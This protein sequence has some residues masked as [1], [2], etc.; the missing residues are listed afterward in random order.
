MTI[1]LLIGSFALSACGLS[2]VYSPN[3]T[4]NDV[5]RELSSIN[6]GS[7]PEKSGVD[8]RNELIDRLYL[9][10]Q[11]QKKY[12][13]NITPINEVN[14]GLGISKDASV[15]RSQLRMEATFKLTEKQTG[16]TLLK[17]TARAVTSYNVLDSHFTTLVSERDARENGI[18]ELAEQIII[19]LDLYFS[20]SNED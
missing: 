20:R 4:T 8:L 18:K 15:T 17:R 10:G 12:Q 1:L 19:Q 7:I 14:A 11:N 13:L 9:H 5:A 6:I 2:P 16:K 3:K